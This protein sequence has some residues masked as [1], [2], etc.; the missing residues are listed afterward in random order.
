MK[1]DFGHRKIRA[2]TKSGPAALN[3]LDKELT[4]AEAATETGRTRLT[5]GDKHAIA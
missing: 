1:F 4:K 3:F 5:I 2:V